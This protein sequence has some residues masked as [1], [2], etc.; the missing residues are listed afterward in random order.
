[1][2]NLFQNAVNHGNGDQLSVCIDHDKK[3]VSIKVK[4]N[5]AIIPA[6]KLPFIFDRLYKCDDARSENGSGLGLAI[7]KELVSSLHGTIS[8]QSIP[9]EGTIFTVML[10]IENP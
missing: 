9:E 4:N 8:A 6:D 3:Y 2:N 1:L 10:P 7:T 5:G